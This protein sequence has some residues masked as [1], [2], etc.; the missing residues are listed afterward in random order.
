MPKLKGSEGCKESVETGLHLE[1]SLQLRCS[2]A[3]TIRGVNSHHPRFDRRRA[4]RQGLL[5][6]VGRIFEASRTVTARLHPSSPRAISAYAS[7]LSPSAEVNDVL[8]EELAEKNQRNPRQREPH[9]AW[10]L[11]RPDLV[12]TKTPGQTALVTSESAS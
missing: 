7:T 10:R 2:G 6:T 5:L 9:V 3:D 4:G 12:R 8:C 1:R 11:Q